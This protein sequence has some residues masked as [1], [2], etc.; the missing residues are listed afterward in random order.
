M[1]VFSMFY[2]TDYKVIFENASYIIWKWNWE[3]EIS[4]E[5]KFCH[6]WIQV[7][8][9]IWYQNLFLELRMEK[10]YKRTEIM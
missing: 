9:Y 10:K 7:F 4:D 6:F 5:N 2:T 3:L 8:L 1:L